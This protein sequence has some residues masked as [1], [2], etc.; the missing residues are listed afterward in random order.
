MNLYQITQELTEIVT[1]IEEQGGEFTDEQIQQLICSQENFKEKVL[2]YYHVV[3]NLSNDVNE[4]KC[5]EKRLKDLRNSREKIVDKLKGVIL[6]AIILYGDLQRNGV[7]SL[8]Y[9]TVRLSTRNSTSVEV[10]E[11]RA[12]DFIVRFCHALLFNQLDIYNVIDLVNSNSNS[13]DNVEGTFT[14]ADFST[15]KINVNLVFPVEEILNNSV[16]QNIFRQIC[17]NTFPEMTYTCDKAKI[18]D[19]EDTEENKTTIGVKSYNKSLQIK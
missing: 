13:K 14:K 12:K 11:E 9:P 15:G 18:K 7:Y 10:D 17:K 2:D 19:L 6:N 8:N 4:C 3:S 16:T 5:E 1:T